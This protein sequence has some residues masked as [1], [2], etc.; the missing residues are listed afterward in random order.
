[1][2]VIFLHGSPASGK[3]TVGVKLSGLTGIPLFHNH[4]AVDTARSLFAFGTPAFGRM[5]AT[6]WRTAFTEA[7]QAEQSFIFTF[8]PE[9][10]VDPR[11]I[12]ELRAIIESAG[13]RIHY[14][15]LVCSRE[16]LLERMGNA[17]RAEFG[18]L[19]DPA[20]FQAIEAQG[21]FDFPDLPEA[22]LVVDTDLHDPDAAAALI[23]TAVEAAQNDNQQ[24]VHADAGY[25]TA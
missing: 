25:G 22:L 4:L 17:A 6:I 18:K 1:M 5:R 15:H 2:H 11:L 8:N 12:A 14:I 19:T 24:V 7:A 3:H 20:L 10:T 23:A 16:S 21:G 9:S 13:G